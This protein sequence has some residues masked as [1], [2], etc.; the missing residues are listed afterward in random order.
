[1]AAPA[2]PAVTPAPAPAPAAPPAPALG[3]AEPLDPAAALAARATPEPAAQT[4][5]HDAGAVADNAGGQEP[6]QGPGA[7]A[8]MSLW[9]GAEMPPAAAAAAPDQAPQPR[10][11]DAPTPA[12]AAAPDPALRPAPKA[13]GTPAGASAPNQAH[14]MADVP[15]ETPAGATASDQ[16]HR[17]ADEPADTPAGAAGQRAAPSAAATPFTPALRP[18]DA[19]HA[20]RPPSHVVMH[21]SL[22]DYQPTLPRKMLKNQAQPSSRGIV[23]F[24]SPGLLA[25]K[26]SDDLGTWAIEKIALTALLLYS[27]A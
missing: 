27:L 9:T 6:G 3:F 24:C 10:H 8:E 18:R 19:P 23:F 7:V 22:G 25:Q 16:G 15:A 4:T 13:A 14:Q 12:G 5:L 2:R 11:V 21:C 26:L 17:P 20:V 1:M